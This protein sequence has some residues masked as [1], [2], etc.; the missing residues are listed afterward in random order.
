VIATGTGRLLPTRLVYV[1][2]NSQLA[3]DFM[4][5]P[6]MTLGVLGRSL[7]AAVK[8]G[9]RLAIGT[10]EA[11]A[12][13]AE[14]DLRVVSIPDDFRVSASGPFDGRYMR[15]LFARGAEV[16]AHGEAVGVQPS[17]LASRDPRG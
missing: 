12:R 8:A 14:I 11:F 13:R 10:H 5:T 16:G 2:V 15:A 4:V 17:R 9:T 3:A 6:P 1:I 7:T